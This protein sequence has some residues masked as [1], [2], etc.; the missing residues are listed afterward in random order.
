MFRKIKIRNRFL[1]FGI[2]ALAGFLVLALLFLYLICRSSAYVPRESIIIKRTGAGASFAQQLVDFGIAPNTILAHIVIQLLK[3]W[4]FVVK[5]GEYDLPENVSLIDAIKILSNGN[6]LVHK[7]T[8]PEGL[9][10]ALVVELLNK[11]KLL[12]GVI[13]EIPEEG[14]LLP[15]TYIFRYPTTRQHIIT[16]A[17]NAMRQ[18]IKREWP[19]KSANCFLKTPREA[20]ILASIVEK[21]TCNEREKIAGIFLNRLRKKMRLQSCPTVIYALKHGLPLGRK[22]MLTDLQIDSPYNT[23]KNHGLPPTPITNP[24]AQSIIAVLHPTM[25][26]YLFFVLGRNKTHVFSK[27]F[28]E[29][30]MNKEM[31]QK[32][33]CNNSIAGEL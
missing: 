21:E 18:F 24:G 27:T 3:Q 6:V 15:D 33:I 20:I 4:G 14:S 19:R 13:S 9:P 30:K 8:I 22:L 17:K 1:F 31:S 11:N 29:H 16:M 23:Y 26:D 5:S 10:I 12:I 32:Y 25:T 2:G 7:I 28:N